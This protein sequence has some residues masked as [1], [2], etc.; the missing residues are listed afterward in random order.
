M[1]TYV[2]FIGDTEKLTS[3]VLEKDSILEF[4]T[5]QNL[6]EVTDDNSDWI[7]I[8]ARIGEIEHFF[9]VQPSDIKIA[10]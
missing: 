5:Q 6:F 7:E 1:K 9:Y 2:N 4:L 3:N 8:Y 10:K